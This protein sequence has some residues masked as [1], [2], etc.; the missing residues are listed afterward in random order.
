[1]MTHSFPT[2]MTITHIETGMHLYGGAQQVVYIIE[3]LAKRG[4]RNILIAPQGSA[5]SE[6][7]SAN[8]SAEVITTRHSGDLSFGFYR[9]VKRILSNNKSD[10]VHIH[11]R[12]GA[13]TLGGLA[14]K[15]IGIPALLSRRVDNRER[16]LAIRL[17]Y[18][19]Y[20]HVIGISQA[21]CD[22]LANQGVDTKKLSCVHSTVDTA[23]FNAT[24][25]DRQKARTSLGKRFKIP[26]ENLLIAVVAQLIPRK[27][28]KHLLAVLPSMLKNN[29]KISV[30]IFGQGPER[31][32]IAKQISDLNLNQHVQLA[33]FCPNLDDNLSGIDI[34]A[35]PADKEG[36]GV[37]LLK[38]SAAGVPIVAGRAGGIPEIVQEGKNGLLFTAN[39]QPELQQALET[40]INN[41]SMRAEMGKT[42]MQIAKNQFS[43]DTMVDGNLAVYKAILN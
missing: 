17:K 40:L 25:D 9:E 20:Q 24:P 35:H 33:G 14:A 39:H 6:I 8:G 19:L 32:T 30:L 29:S 31:D 11:S 1:M 10:L 16:R 23:R 2:S 42:G 4:I 41:P 22:V 27:G 26:D 3:G 43:I 15:A 18:P 28:H 13:D 34:I 5:I 38:A 12:R 36:L 37:A 7:V 21:I